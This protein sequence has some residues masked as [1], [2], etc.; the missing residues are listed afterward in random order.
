MKF[1]LYI[2][3]VF[4][5]LL[6]PTSSSGV[7]RDSINDVIFDWTIVSLLVFI[8]LI[9]YGKLDRK[10]TIIGSL[11]IFYLT[12]MTLVSNRSDSYSTFSIAR[13][14]PV[15]LFLLLSST[16]IDYKISMNKLFPLFDIVIITIIVF[17]ILIIFDNNIVKHFIINNYSQFYESATQNMFIK[18]RP[19]FT[20]GVYTFASYFYTI[21]FLLCTYSYE[22]TK[23][24]KYRFYYFILLIFNI[25]LAS[26]FSILSSLFMI[27]V[28]FR[29][30]I[31][32][33]NSKEIVFFSLFISI[34]IVWLVNNKELIGYYQESLFSLEN[35]F[36]G[37]YSDSGVLMINNEYLKTHPNI[38]FNIIRNKDLTYTDSGYFVVRLMGGWILLIPFYYLLYRFIKNNF[39]SKYLTFLIITLVFETVIPVTTYIKF[40]YAMIF[41]IV[42]LSSLSSHELIKFKRN[43]YGRS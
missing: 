40:I 16:K 1:F 22:I 3:I 41:C 31:K 30:S 9:F 10:N 43:D 20:F 33:R 42:Y 23:K 15:C 28:I 7:I 36:I 2:I 32:N 17:N 24:N 25:L 37:R 34:I 6:Y 29:T 38:G 12:I 11:I 18:K 21:L 35:G 5:F 14:A 13:F 39:R 27:F 26:N 4:L 8:V 19:V